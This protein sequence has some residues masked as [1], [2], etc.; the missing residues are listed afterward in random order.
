MPLLGLRSPE[1]V[2]RVV[3][4]PAPLPPMRVT[5]EP[6][7]TLSEMPLSAEIAP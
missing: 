3:V 1:M 2:R 5:M 4:F 7:A 6:W